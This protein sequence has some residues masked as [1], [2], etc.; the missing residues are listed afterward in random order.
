MDGS[1]RMIVQGRHLIWPNALTVDYPT[2]TL[3]WGD[4]KHHAFESSYYDGSNRRPIILEEA[5][6]PFAMS[7]FEDY[8]YWTDWETK[9]IR[10]NQKC[11]GADITE[12]FTNLYQPMDVHVVHK[13]RQPMP[14]GKTVVSL[15]SAHVF[16][17]NHSIKFSTAFF[18]SIFPHPCLGS[19][20][21][22]LLI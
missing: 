21:P 12:V 20:Y 8:M 17:P 7:I 2:K 13:A 11:G 10:K 4:A 6:H 18:P 5:G 14:S 1:N 22:P 3:Y 16:F 19:L 15:L 9:S